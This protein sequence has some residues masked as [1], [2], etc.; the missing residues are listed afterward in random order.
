VICNEEYLSIT[1]NHLTPVPLNGR[2]LLIL[3]MGEVVVF[4]LNSVEDLA[5]LTACPDHLQY[6]NQGNL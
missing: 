5:I 6:M 4:S 1:K 2:M 3:L